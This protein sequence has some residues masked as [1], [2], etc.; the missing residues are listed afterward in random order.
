MGRYELGEELTSTHRFDYDQTL[1]ESIKSF[2]RVLKIDRRPS[3]IESNIPEKIQIPVP[4]VADEVF[5]VDEVKTNGEHIQPL[6]QT[7]GYYDET[8]NH[9]SKVLKKNM[10]FFCNKNLEFQLSSTTTI[11]ST[12]SSIT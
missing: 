10:F 4:A 11:F 3:L 1:M 5:S 6:L 7:N 12:T 2:G 9:Q 8:Y